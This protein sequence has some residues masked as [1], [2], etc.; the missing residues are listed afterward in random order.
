VT[1]LY[2]IQDVRER[3]SQDTSFEKDLWTLLDVAEHYYRWVIPNTIPD[4]DA[5]AHILDGDLHIDEIFHFATW[6]H[7]IVE[8][9]FRSVCKRLDAEY[10]R[11]VHVQKR[12]REV[13]AHELEK[14][15]DGSTNKLQRFFYCVYLLQCIREKEIAANK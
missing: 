7:L 13:V 15:L 10:G 3:Y 4:D 9:C 12:Y 2:F 11:W 14:K 6:V 5:P 8:S 1:C